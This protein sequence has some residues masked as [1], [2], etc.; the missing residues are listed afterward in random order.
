MIGNATMALLLGIDHLDVAS[1]SL[2]DRRH[3]A[4]IGPHGIPVGTAEPASAA[5]LRL[6]G[7]ALRLDPDSVDRTR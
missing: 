2:V 6:A 4:A 7:P 5:L 3:D 1:R